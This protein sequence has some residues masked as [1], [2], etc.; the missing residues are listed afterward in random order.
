MYLNDVF[1][2]LFRIHTVILSTV[3]LNILQNISSCIKYIYILFYNILENNIFD[4]R[5]KNISFVNTY[6]QYSFFI[7]Y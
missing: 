3:S 7:F 1:P 5:D 4:T 6:F 2:F